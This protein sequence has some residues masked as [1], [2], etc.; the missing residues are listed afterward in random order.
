MEINC[1]YWS[2]VQSSAHSKWLSHLLSPIICLTD[3]R[4]TK[5]AACVQDIL[6]TPSPWAVCDLLSNA[7]SN[8]LPLQEPYCCIIIWLHLFY[9]KRVLLIHCLTCVCTFLSSALGLPL[10]GLI[11]YF[12][13]LFTASSGWRSI[14]NKSAS[15]LNSLGRACSCA[16]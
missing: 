12:I 5:H 8:S 16:Y 9:Y 11:F 3:K 1:I 4:C 14:L 15:L 2:L 10:S 7:M 13:L 6:I